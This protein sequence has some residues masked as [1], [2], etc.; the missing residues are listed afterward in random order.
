MNVSVM[1]SPLTRQTVEAKDHQALSIDA[2]SP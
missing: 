1:D 2:R